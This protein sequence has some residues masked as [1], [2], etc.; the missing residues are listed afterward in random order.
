MEQYTSSK[1]R[2]FSSWLRSS[3]DGKQLKGFASFAK[4]AVTPDPVKMSPIVLDMLFTREWLNEPDVD[5]PDR[6]NR[7]VQTEVILS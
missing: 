1:Y 6:T 2:T 4:L 5:E 7:D 3:T